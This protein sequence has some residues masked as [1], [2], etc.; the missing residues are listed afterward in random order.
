[1]QFANIF[2]LIYNFRNVTLKTRV[3]FAQKTESCSDFITL[4]ERLKFPA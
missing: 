3:K 1:M 2:H 4:L